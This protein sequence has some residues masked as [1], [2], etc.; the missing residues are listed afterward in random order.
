MDRLDTLY[1]Y[2]DILTYTLAHGGG[3][4]DSRTLQ[5]VELTAGYAVALATGTAALVDDVR[6]GLYPALDN[7]RR[8]HP[9][10][11]YIGT[12]RDPDGV[13]HIDPVVIIP[14]RASALTLGRALGQLAVWSFAESSELQAA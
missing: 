11:P 6:T 8:S 10:A 13:V 7:V 12:W 1:A 4:F 14:D 5:P 9:D 3:T 2:D